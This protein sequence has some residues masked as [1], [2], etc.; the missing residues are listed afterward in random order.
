MALISGPG[1][2]GKEISRAATAQ[3]V[4][5]DLADLQS[6]VATQRAS[7]ARIRALLAKA[8]SLRDVVLL[9]SEVTKREAELEA[10]QAR[11]AALA[12]RADL[13]TLTVDLRTSVAAAAVRA[14]ER[15]AFLTGLDGGWQALVA[16]TGVVLTILGGLLPF[17]VVAALVGVPVLVLLRRRRRATVKP[18]AAPPAPAPGAGA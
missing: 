3:D 16:S 11:Q 10:L 2:V 7:V 17:A 15:S 13:A 12:D 5:G 14:E 4:T 1:G 8:G 9:E 18:A 6:R